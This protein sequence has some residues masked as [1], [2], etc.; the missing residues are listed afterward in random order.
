MNRQELVSKLKIIRDGLNRKNKYL[1]E[2]IPESKYE[3]YMEYVPIK[4]IAPKEIEEP[5]NAQDRFLEQEDIN[6]KPRYYYPD[7]RDVSFH[8]PAW[9]RGVLI[10]SLILAVLIAIVGWIVISG[11]NNTNPPYVCFDDGWGNYTDC[12]YDYS[13][14]EGA[15]QRGYI[16]FIVAGA[17]AGIAVLMPVISLV[18]LFVEKSAA[19]AKIPAQDKSYR[20]SL[21]RQNE[22]NKQKKEKALA[23][24]AIYEEKL[25]EY[26]E[27]Y[28]EYSNKMAD[29]EERYNEQKEIGLAKI[30]KTNKELDE[31]ANHALES[32]LEA[33][34]MEYPEKYYPNIDAIIDI[35]VDMRADTLKEAINVFLDDQRKQELLYLNS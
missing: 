35:L 32:A 19:R 9:Q 24:Y 8:F 28:D 13:Q 14:I 17:V 10:A 5:S 7:P 15:R 16:T 2:K 11:A 29:Y 22:I 31:K 6:Q 34:D 4:P 26:Y 23:D 25:P 20:E 18:R 27:E 1:S 33:V 30:R 12:R 3:K 21:I